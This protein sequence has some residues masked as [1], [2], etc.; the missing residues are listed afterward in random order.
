MALS[1]R[2]IGAWAADRAVVMRIAADL[3]TR[4]TSGTLERYSDLPSSS[5]LA[6]QWDTATR[7]VSRAKRLL[8]DRGLIKKARDG[9]YYVA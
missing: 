8:L 1:D 3:A 4:I 5:E 9:S 6:V 7:T 2:E